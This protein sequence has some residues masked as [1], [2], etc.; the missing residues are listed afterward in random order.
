MAENIPQTFRES[1]SDAE[2]EAFK[3]IFDKRAKEPDGEYQVLAFTSGETL[4]VLLKWFND[5]VILDNAS[6]TERD[7]LIAREIKAKLVESKRV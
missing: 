7:Y 2:F 4:E 5:L 6:I 3:K 1:L